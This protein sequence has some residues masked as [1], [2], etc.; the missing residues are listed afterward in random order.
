VVLP[1]ERCH[2]K[3]LYID[4]LHV[5]QLLRTHIMPFREHLKRILH[6]DKDR[7]RGSSRGNTPEQSSSTLTNV[8]TPNSSSVSSDP[9]PAVSPNLAADPV[10][11]GIQAGNAAT[12]TFQPPI[13]TPI[14]PTATTPST[15]VS[16]LTANKTPAKPN[17]VQS[18]S[19]NTT[20]ETAWAGLKT[21]LGLLNE[22]SDAFGSL[23]SAIGGI[24]GCIEIFEV[25]R[26][27]CSTCFTFDLH[28]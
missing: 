6:R 11:L 10:S 26:S 24:N 20:K 21:F 28:G 18:T 3:R 22:S 19:P 4:P 7:I 16:N 5:P 27:C 25:R 13:V 2:F 1:A 9:A 17:P 15:A 12:A 23:K 8:H 14:P